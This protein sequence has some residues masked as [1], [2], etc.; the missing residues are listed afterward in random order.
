MAAHG[1]PNYTKQIHD[2]ED[3]QKDFEATHH[4]A[5]PTRHRV[6]T[7][8]EDEFHRAI[9]LNKEQ[10]TLKRQQEQRDIR[11]RKHAEQQEAEAE[12]R[13]QEAAVRK[14]EIAVRKQE[15]ENRKQS[16]HVEFDRNREQ[17]HKDRVAAEKEQ[18][19]VATAQA[20]I[21]KNVAAAQ[22]KQV[23][24][25]TLREETAAKRVR[26]IEAKNRLAKKAWETA[27]PSERVKIRKA[28]DEANANARA[29]GLIPK[30]EYKSHKMFGGAALGVA[31][32][33]T[34]A[35]LDTASDFMSRHDI[36]NPKKPI[37]RSALHSVKK[38]TTSEI[39][40]A[41]KRLGTHQKAVGITGLGTKHQIKAYARGQRIAPQ[42]MGTHE[43]TYMQNI[44]GNIAAPPEPSHPT[45]VATRAGRE[46]GKG[47]PNA[48]V[49][50]AGT[51]ERRYVTDGHGRSGTRATLEW[52][53]EHRN[54]TS[55]ERAA[56]ASVNQ[57]WATDVTGMTRPPVRHRKN[58][59]RSSSALDN[60][61]KRL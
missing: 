60:F 52:R 34:G 31:K 33:G 6:T 61:V 24:Q 40:D 12:M 38:A 1:D 11:S 55:P 57:N 29:K 16:R 13:R 18:R 19:R 50:L 2:L 3:Q 23:Q 30:A 45:I 44:L 17:V 14:Q 7:K 58:G 48:G 41:G 35:A 28:I 49:V 21:D 15:A 46:I 37:V 43:Q 10:N 56:K 47:N 32:A 53:R 39:N 54:Y 27:S 4:A 42:P 20:E 25:D 59:V 9:E 26:E 22:R 5:P 8:D 36:Y 51:T